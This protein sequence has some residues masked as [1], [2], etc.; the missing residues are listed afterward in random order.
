MEVLLYVV[1]GAYLAPAA[2]IAIF[3]WASNT[4]RGFIA[5]FAGIFLGVAWPFIAYTVA[6]DIMGDRYDDPD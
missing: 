1:G 5:V 6:R 2:I 4:E 3:I